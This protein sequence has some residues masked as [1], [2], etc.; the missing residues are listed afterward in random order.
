MTRANLRA[1]DLLLAVAV[2]AGMVLV[3]VLGRTSGGGSDTFAASDFRSGGY[4]AWFTLLQREGITTQSFEHRPAE[5]DARIATLIAATPVVPSDTGSRSAADQAALAGWVFAG[6]RLVAI[7]DGDAFQSAGSQAA[8]V[9]PKMLTVRRPRGPLRGPLA[10]GIAH[11]AGLSGDRFASSRRDIALLVDGGGAIV[12]RVPY[13]RG[14]IDY[15][16]DAQPFANRWIAH[17]DNARLAYA[18]AQSGARGAVAFD[19]TLHGVLIE[20]GWWQAI[21]V[22][23][24][25]ALA[26]IALAMLIALAGSTLRLGPALVLREVREPASDEFIAAVAALYQRNG[27]RR[28]AIALLAAGAQSAHGPAADELRRLAER[29]SPHDRDLIAS[30][31]LARA[32]REGT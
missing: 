27:A 10:I 5:L 32:I 14:E 16:G 2:L 17:A 8:G 30:A 26:G 20:R 3:A 4:A 21:D 11:L 31:A 15:V 7:G 24:R 25:V 12:V 18:L 23:E 28:A 19:E 9:R 29:Q 13:G 6:G 22:P 1:S